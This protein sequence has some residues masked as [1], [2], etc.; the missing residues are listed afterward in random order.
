MFG[1]R[2]GTVIASR[3]LLFLYT[4]GFS[5]AVFLRRLIHNSQEYASIFMN[6]VL[7]YSFWPC[8]TI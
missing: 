2:V 1:P 3:L 6:Y 5:F 4:G 8:M 7:F